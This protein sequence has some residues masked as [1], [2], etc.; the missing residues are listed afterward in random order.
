MGRPGTDV[1]SGKRAGTARFQ[2]GRAV[3]GPRPRHVGRP[4][5]ARLS[6]RA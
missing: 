6:K 2:I 5:P 1:P 3:L 4:G